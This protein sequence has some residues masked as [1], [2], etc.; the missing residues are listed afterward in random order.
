MIHSVWFGKYDVKNSFSRLDKIREELESMRQKGL[1]IMTIK[2]EHDEIQV[3][4]CIDKIGDII[5][6]VQ[7]SLRLR[8]NL[9]V[10]KSLTSEGEYFQLTHNRA[11]R[12]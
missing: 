8:P 10:R 6:D 7:L 2:S 1:P 3:Q 9:T 12:R 5:T 4:A 11:N